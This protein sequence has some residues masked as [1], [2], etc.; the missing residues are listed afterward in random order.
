MKE[1]PKSKRYALGWYNE[2][3]TRL[4]IKDYEEAM[5]FF[6]K[7]LETIP[8]HPDFLIGLGD[9]FFATGRF[10]E[11][12]EKYI[13]TLH[14][15]PDNFQAWLKTGIALLRL[16]KTEEALEV[17]DALVEQNAYDGELWLAHGLALLD[18]GQKEKA[19]VSFINAR[20]YKPNQPALWY[21]LARMEKD[22]IGALQLLQRGYHMDV[23]N[24]DILI[25]LTIRLLALGRMEESLQ[26][27][28]R[29]RGVS[30]ENPRVH[31]LMQQCLDAMK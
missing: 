23:T 26:Y 10:K 31:K 4:N 25:E 17:F 29:A 11:A 20:R 24:L 19:R 21:E 13:Q 5:E 12:Y 15:E 30:P 8:D 7:A 28:E 2:G 6:H 22:D 14:L 18:L 3:I 16:K 9:V 1:I 27:C